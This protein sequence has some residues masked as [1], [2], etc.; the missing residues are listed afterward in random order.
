MALS[1]MMQHYLQTK[2]KYHDAIVFYRLGDFYEMFFEDALTA[3]KEL[4]ITL[5]GRDC[6]LEERAPMCGIPYHAAETYIAK[7]VSLGYKVAICEQLTQPQKG[8]KIVERD[9]VRVVTAGTVTEDSM[10]EEGKNNFL[11]SVN[12]NKQQVGLAYCDLTTGDTFAMQITDNDSYSN[13]SDALARILP[14]EIIGN[15]FA[16]QIGD[17]LPNTILGHTPKFGK[18]NQISF[19]EA[20]LLLEEQ[21]GKDYRK[22]FLLQENNEMLLALGMLTEYLKE[23]Q[24]KS[25]SHMNQVVVIQ[26]QQ[27]LHLDLNT[28]RNLEIS[29]TLNGR[30]KKGSLL[31]VLDKTETS[32]GAR[33]LR[34]WVD[35]PLF[36]EKEIALRQ[37]G[38]NELFLSNARREGVAH[39]LSNMSDI[40]RICGKISLGNLN[41]RDCLSL[42]NT[43]AVIPELKQELQF[44]S[45]KALSSLRERIGNYEPIEHAIK[46]SINENAPALIANGNII[47]AGYHAQLDELRSLATGGKEILAKLE[48]KER[49]RTGIKN[50]KVSFNR[51]FGYFIEVNKSQS[52][53]VPFDYVRKQTVANNERYITPELKEIEEKIV[54]SEEQSQKLEIALFENIRKYLLENLSAL[55]SLAKIVANIDCLQSLATVAVKHNYVMPKV[56][57]KLSK[58]EITEGRHPVIEAILKD[59]QFISN[60]T[61]IN[62]S[63]D[64][65][66][67]ITGPNMAGKST[68]M[69]QVALITFMAHIGSFVPAKKAEIALTDRIFT[70]VGASDDLALGQSTFM[71]E[72]LEVANIL[73]HA[74]PK[75]L[76][77]LDEVG[78]GTATFDGLS[79]AWAVIEHINNEIK[80]KTLFSTHYH[81]LTELEGFLEGVKNYRISVKEVGDKVVFLRKV[82]RGGT[83]K[84]FGIEVARLAGVPN[85]VI[86]RSREILKK[87][88]QADINYMFPAMNEQEIKSQEDGVKVAKDILRTLADL[89]INTLSPMHAF[90]IL[91]TLIEKAKG[92]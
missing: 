37:Q 43:L 76:L 3:S 74:T 84:S 46:D 61:L 60:D 54:S 87:L 33:L 85:H 91:A 80:P 58:I 66:I 75:S 10:L 62:D 24:K 73:K 63:T 13:L 77:I 88:E 17:N 53:L 8:V 69:R 29:E 25:F 19:E 90:D 5:T 51:V 16:K 4:D 15:E 21:F 22:K 70:R 14:A 92:E 26:S 34:Q 40:D 31:W 65:T 50:L 81:E 52:D 56:S 82:V 23:T 36:D 79:I 55:Q 47:R 20:N 42:A 35:E 6:G 41:P 64:R 59:E 7:L 44:F 32:M 48:L 11:A 38:V 71:V 1:P 28:R 78:R 27:F 2:E 39:L 57:A 9:V 12:M 49:E 45:H 30:K 83:N 86:L 67:I 68:F 72:M 18:R 89:N